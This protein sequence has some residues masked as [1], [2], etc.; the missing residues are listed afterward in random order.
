MNFW[1]KKYSLIILLLIY[2]LSYFLQS[3]FFVD[4]WG[5]FAENPT[6]KTNLIAVFVDKNIYQESKS[7][8]EWYSKDYIQQK[9]SNSKAL[10]LPINV[11]NFGAIDLVRMLE[12]LYFDWVK[13][14]S[15]SLLGAVFIWDIPLPVVENNWFLYPSIFPYVDFK[16]QQF[17]YDSDSKFF[18]SNNNPRGQAEIWHWIVNFWTDHK[19]YSDYFDKLKTYTSDP[20]SFVSRSLRYDDFVAVKE[21]FNI[22]NLPFYVNNFLFLEDVGYHRYTNLMLDYFIATQN[23]SAYD[24]VDS[25]SKDNPDLAN[26]VSGEL[27]NQWRSTVP[28]VMLWS[29]IKELLVKYQSLYADTFLAKIRTNTE[30][31]GRWLKE[32]SSWFIVNAVDSHIHKT[33][34]LDSLVAGDIETGLS[35]LI[36]SFNQLMEEELD[37]KIEKEKRYMTYP[38]VTDYKHMKYKNDWNWLRKYCET[39]VEDHYK[40]YYFGIY[41]WEITSASQFSNY[42]WTFRNLDSFSGVIL[43]NEIFNSNNL[44]SLWAS[45]NLFAT[46]VDANRWYNLFSVAGDYASYEDNKIKTHRRY[47]CTKY[48]IDVKIGKKRY[49]YICRRSAPQYVWE[50]EESLYDFA[51]RWWGWASALNLDEEKM[52]EWI[53]ELKDYNY[54]SSML[55]I[56]DIWGSQAISDPEVLSESFL[57]HSEY[58]SLIKVWDRYGMLE[59]PKYIWFVWDLDNYPDSVYWPI[60]KWYRQ[61]IGTQKIFY[62]YDDLDFFTQWIKRKNW[63]SSPRTN[64]II[65]NKTKE[66]N[67]SVA[68]IW[69]KCWSKRETYIYE[70]KTIDTRIKN[71]LPTPDSINGTYRDDFAEDWLFGKHYAYLSNDLAYISGLL[72]DVFGD[73]NNKLTDLSNKTDSLNGRIELF[74]NSKSTDTATLLNLVGAILPSQEE[75]VYSGVLFDA[76]EQ[77]EDIPS[78]ISEI[79]LW[80]SISYFN[81]IAEI[82]SLY[83]QKT[84]FLSWWS[85]S[86]WETSIDLQKNYKK[87]DIWYST[88]KNHYNNIYKKYNFVSKIEKKRSDL[89]LKCDKDHK[90]LCSKIDALI[91]T[92][93]WYQNTLFNLS[94]YE[95]ILSGESV[96]VKPISI[97]WEALNPDLEEWELSFLDELNY[98]R[99]ELWKIEIVKEYPE[100]TH[101]PWLNQATKDRA[102][103][104]PKNITFQWVWG[105][106]V[107]LVYPN[108]YDIEVY[109]KEGTNLILKSPQEIEASIY[110]YLR[111]KVKEYNTLLSG[112]D[113]KKLKYYTDNASAFDFLFKADELASAKDRKFKPLLEGFFIDLLWEEQISELAVLLYYQTLPVYS[114]K[115][116]EFVE[117]DLNEIRSTFDI[118][119]KIWFIMSGY[120]REWNAD[121]KLSIP[122]YNST[123]YEMA[124]INSDRSDYLSVSD[125]PTFLKEIE[126]SKKSIEQRPSSV[127]SV[128]E[129]AFV[130][131]MGQKCGLDSSYS[132]YLF[133]KDPVS[134]EMTFPWFDSLKCWWTELL[135]YDDFLDFS[136]E[137]WSWSSF[138]SW[139]Q[140]TFEDW[141]ELMK[142]RYNPIKTHFG[143]GKDDEPWAVFEWDLAEYWGNVIAWKDEEEI[144]IKVKSI[145]IKTPARKILAWTQIPIGVSAL[146][147]SGNIIK[148]TIDSYQLSV[149]PWFGEFL[150]PGSSGWVW[151]EFSD[152]V[153]MFLYQA[154]DVS[155]P[156]NVVLTLSGWWLSTQE[157]I[158][159][160]PGN[161]KISFAWH[162]IYDNKKLNSPIN[163]NL[164]GL[165]ST[166]SSLPR[167]LVSLRGSD[168]SD[169]QTSFSVYSKNWLIAPGVISDW[170]FHPLR[171]YFLEKQEQ[172]I[173]LM[174]NYQVWSDELYIQIPWL[175]PI[176]IPVNVNPWNPYRV[177]LITDVDVYEVWE[178]FSGSFL[179][180]DKRW[181]FI[182]EKIKLK[183]WSLGALDLSINTVEVKQSYEFSTTTSEP[184]WMS[185]LYWILDGVSLV[186]QSPAYKKI[187]VQESF[188]PQEDLNVMYLNLFGSDWWNIWSFD[189]SIAE[190]IPN[191]VSNSNK[192]LAVTTLSSTP[193]RL[194]K[195]LWV[196][197]YDGQVYNFSTNSVNLKI[198]SWYLLSEFTN[199]W[200]VPIALSKNISLFS[201]ENPLKSLE[202]YKAKSPA[203][204]ISMED[205]ED[206]LELTDKTLSYSWELLLDL[207]NWFWNETLEIRLADYMQKWYSV[208]ELFYNSQQIWELYFVKWEEEIK[209]D[210]V[211]LYNMLAYDKKTSFAEWTTNW[212]K[213]VWLIDLFWVFTKEGF[214]SIEDSNETDLWIGFTADFKNITLFGDGKMVWEATI[215]FGSQFL[216]N[217]GDPLLSRIS[218][219]LE[220]PN[221]PLDLWIGKEVYTNP[222]KSILKVLDLDFNNDWLMDLL[223]VFTDWTIKLL[224]SYWGTNSYENMD[225]LLRLADSIKDVFVGD[226][227][228]NNYPDI[229]VWTTSD[230]LRVYTNDKWVL[231][232]DGKMI[233]LNT[234]VDRGEIQENPEFI[235][236]LQQVY[237]EDM[238]NDWNIDIVVND[239]IWNIKIFYWWSKW[240]KW[241][242]VST[243]EYACDDDRYNRQ[244]DQTKLVKSF[245]IT[246]NSD[247]YVQDDSL[248]HLKGWKIGDDSSNDLPDDLPDLSFLDNL[249]SASNIDLAALLQN[250]VTDVSDQWVY[251]ML[252]NRFSVAPISYVPSYESGLLLAEVWYKTLLQLSGDQSISIYKQY[253]DLNGGVL[254]DWDT[255]RVTT[256]ILGLNE[257]VKATYID[258]LKWPWEVEIGDEKEILSF[259]KESGNFENIDIVWQDKDDIMFVMDNIDLNNRQTLK[260]SYDLIYRWEPLVKMSIKDVKLEDKKKTRDDYKDIIVNPLDPCEKYRWIFFNTSSQK[261]RSY[262][263]VWDDLSQ[264]MDNYIND[265]EWEEAFSV[266]DLFDSDGEKPKLNK[267]GECDKECAKNMQSIIG[268]A[269]DSLSDQFSTIFESWQVP[270]LSDVFS[271]WWILVVNEFMAWVVDSVDK[272]TDSLCEW[273][274]LG[275]DSCQPPFPLNQI[276]FNQA[277]LAPG[278]YHLF[279]CVP[280]FP[281]PLAPL[282]EI[283]N[284]NLWGGF[285]ALFFPATIRIPAV[286][287][288]VPIP[289]VGSSLIPIMQK[290]PWDGFWLPPF[291]PGWWAFPSMLRVYL[292]PTLTMQMGVAICAGPYMGKLD[293]PVLWDLWWNCV[294]ATFPLYTC[295]EKDE[296][297]IGVVPTEEIDPWMLDLAEQ[298]SCDKISINWM[299]KVLANSVI[300][301]QETKSSPFRLS[302]QWEQSSARSPAA[303]NV[304]L[305]Y[306]S[307]ASSP[308]KN[309]NLN[310]DVSRVRGFNFDPF[311]FFQWPKIDLSV[312]W[313]DEK[314]IINKVVNERLSRQIKYMINNLTKLNISI[315]LPDISQMFEGFDRLWSAEIWAQE[316]EE[317]RQN[318]VAFLTWDKDNKFLKNMKDFASMQNYQ[319]ATS[320]LNNPFD[321]LIG[322]FDEIPLIDLDTKDIVIKIPL[323]TTE[324]LLKYKSYSVTWLDNQ[325]KILKQRIEAIYELSHFCGHM[326]KQEAMEELAYLEEEE[327]RIEKIKFWTIWDWER[328][329]LLD[330]IKIEKEFANLVLDKP[331]DWWYSSDDFQTLFANIS[332]DTSAML[333]GINEYIKSFSYRIKSHSRLKYTK[334]CLENPNLA[335]CEP[336]NDLEDKN[337][338]AELAKVSTRKKEILTCASFAG[339]LDW[340]KEFY[341]DA[342]Q[343]SRHVQQNLDVLDKYTQ[344]PLQLY[345]WM[346]FVDNTISSVLDFVTVLST[347]IIA[348]L[349]VNAKLY[350]KWVDALI[351]IL[352]SIKTYQI[353]IDITA[354]WSKNCG[355]CSRDSFSPYACSF[356]NLFPK[357][358]ILKIPPFKIP[359]INI[360]FSHIDLWINMVLPRFVFVPIDLALPSLPDLPRP[361]N[362]NL[363][364]WIDF[365]IAFDFLLPKIPILPEPPVL[366]DLPEFIPKLDLNLPNL[367]PPA[368]KIPDLIPEL[369]VVLDTVELISKLFC[370]LKS[371]PLVLESR[372]KYKVEQ[373]TQRTRDVEWIDYLDQ[374]LRWNA[375]EKLQ[376]F[377]LQM[378]GYMQFKTDFS[379]F[380]GALN[381][382]AGVINS[383]SYKVSDAFSENVVG[384]INTWSAWMEDLFDETIDDINIDLD[385]NFPRLDIST[386]LFSYDIEWD[387]YETTYKHLNQQLSIIKS[388]VDNQNILSD[389]DQTIASLNAEYSINPMTANVSKA[390]SE[391]NDILIAKQKEVRDISS[392][393]KSYDKF[394]AQIRNDNIAFV[395]DEKIE[396]KIS[397]PIFSTNK[398]TIDFLSKSDSILDTYAETNLNLANDLINWIKS[399]SSEDWG[400]SDEDFVEATSL[401]DSMQLSLLDVA[402]Q[403]WLDVAD[404]CGSS[405]L[406]ASQSCPT[407]VWWWAGTST[408]VLDISN[409]VRWVFLEDPESGAMVNVI[410]SDEF[411]SKI[412]DR[413]FLVDMNNDDLEDMV[414]W[415]NNSVY[416]KYAKQ[417]SEIPNLIVNKKSYV[418]SPWFFASPYIDSYQELLQKTE[419]KDGYVDFGDISVKLASPFQEVKNFKISGQSFDAIQ[420]SWRNSQSLWEPVDWYL[421][422]LN[423][424]IDTHK[425]KWVNHKFLN[426]EFLNQRY[427]LILPADTNYSGA[428]IDFKEAYYYKWKKMDKPADVIEFLSWW[429]YSELIYNVKSYYPNMLN[430]SLG[431]WDIPRNWQYA[432]IVPLKNR[433][434]DDKPD[435]IPAGPWSNQLVAW[436]QILS[437]TIWPE[438]NV[439]LYRPSIEEVVSEWTRHQWFV[440]TNYDLNI[441]WI[442]NVSVANMRIEQDWDI[443]LGKKA[444][445]PLADIQLTGLY[446][447]GPTNLEYIIWAEDSNGNMQLEKVSLEIEVPT[448]DVI[449]YVQISES[450]GQLIAELSDDIDEWMVVFQR[451]R[452]DQRKEIAGTLSNSYGWYFVGPRQ[453]II[454]GAVFSLWNDVGLYDAFG[455]EIW[456]IT[457]DGEISILPEHQAQYEIVL[458]LSSGFPLIRVLDNVSNT[459][460]FWIQMAST[461]L[462]DIS[463]YQRE[464]FYTKLDLTQDM[465]GAFVGGTCIQA[466][467]KECIMYI[468]PIWQIYLPKQFASSL[469][470][471][472]RFDKTTRSVIY[473]IKDFLWKDLLRVTTKT[474][475]AK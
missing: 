400:L 101:V 201:T 155:S 90:V 264:K 239:A 112:Q 67:Q 125:T 439:S 9:I 192:L 401:L 247:L 341:D 322:I 411:I 450:S 81:Y 370:L 3:W 232:V 219:N 338:E 117:W 134:D 98:F 443:I 254:V 289:V 424:R 281:H 376:G 89:N 203:I 315:V 317:V 236:W 176:K 241:N 87:L 425:D 40:N 387:N 421:L 133:L 457:M 44:K 24:L 298:W 335:W 99:K 227:D 116:S 449:D 288:P 418:Y 299:A 100:P 472:Y 277:F 412:G 373:L 220:L 297:D 38:I 143:F 151:P 320:A 265:L 185:Y 142:E 23:N 77:I 152:F 464:P 438:A 190:Y 128:I 78:K 207:S 385:F 362:F 291:P 440:G 350:S 4:L 378:D 120:I 351:L 384:R 310:R 327:S 312:V 217:F 381:Q 221:L 197:S 406:L 188:L 52:P 422:K 230:Q 266:D 267:D 95:E 462:S 278:D 293:I 19:K 246:V 358:P 313:A 170:E 210:D 53:Y 15:S 26:L 344:F 451:N 231:D 290:W 446:F 228:G 235:K 365:A 175:D 229:L 156:Q 83:D 441:E 428:K 124:Y 415:T 473:V 5:V 17:I 62:S 463:L 249:D 54:K 306:I 137:H 259:K 416:I 27:I 432:Q 129:D 154:P 377:D 287:A 325:R 223:V 11:E 433:W 7:D 356:E 326:T 226:V 141:Y 319:A 248:I 465:F 92:L 343:L 187:L 360:D 394:I 359:N 110:L 8:I 302:S 330:I 66:T 214:K 453:T 345:D 413:F 144:W 471:E 260:F 339:E 397:S 79:N 363:S 430:I 286:V 93:S 182:D 157:T 139:L 57:W 169:L 149:Q 206:S 184:W 454:T 105:D 331:D 242:Y 132:E 244:K 108:I 336:W 316:R 111:N 234:N 251:N 50:E 445:S 37:S 371:G 475:L 469:L 127:V 352:T 96:S 279:G 274:K 292:I 150:S 333:A 33:S 85:S 165:D 342:L 86:L 200:Y 436:R 177:E 314:G 168:G 256:T 334:D 208:W 21:R 398:S 97:I 383:F 458:D 59:Y 178:T 407:C 423:H 272:L 323:P 43:K 250:I 379:L 73:A 280:K 388:R 243:L 70:Y 346:D 456:Q 258:S 189:K 65:V 368:P 166:Y 211:V 262:E 431:L 48:L 253:K 273:F 164:T 218:D 300:I 408:S 16:D 130:N 140:D 444:N 119:K 12:N 47:T 347:S 205:S 28:T 20:W 61:I 173:F 122:N 434:T 123:G 147:M 76:A 68:T 233:C 75:E 442:D 271:S 349:N 63:L 159:V 474:N 455:N 380:Y 55:P 91:N 419:S 198:L 104:G 275:G 399:S 390:Y 225:D 36:M 361:P 179:I 46:Q 283:L 375:D 435:Y 10:V 135:D 58:A 269:W 1:Y 382:I 461:S 354:N 282:F 172:A 332:D 366:P 153:S 136:M 109:K 270:N 71:I 114:K 80:N 304:N 409:Y 18:I 268:N 261:H 31:A 212:R 295:N 296:D 121:E 171:S 204:F 216:I 437:D 285:P 22:G 470:G 427:V 393:I 395:N 199:V 276:P 255:V 429:K 284:K 193:S 186:D 138:F 196:V 386:G 106:V 34:L 403:A 88:L 420:M 32:N 364:A 389:I 414:I 84:Q 348:W 145:S 308:I 391:L 245:G 39:T 311:S 237:F 45:N 25:L 163:I 224:K 252:T 402:D 158:V 404:S 115:D 56:Y 82:E 257:W 195:H 324:D 410:K 222:N 42:L 215:P 126:Q 303:S 14:E 355:T 466:L 69:W 13:W 448:I 160:V 72:V 131:Q 467:D 167:I 194:E 369:S 64:E 49:Q 392:S 51:L 396:L 452:N 174:P 191:I 29:S 367:L 209:L 426:D 238:D 240:W 321:A 102:I 74:I 162:N 417:N 60:K 305:G 202:N 107:K 405:T 447:T 329:R 161:L 309:N 6:N 113:A 328:K 301:Q 118:N 307:L 183:I 340:F 263:E 146:D 213:G 94:G 318:A 353:L 181:N 374:T 41:A 294:V 35:P 180:T 148:N 30:A 357:I 468:S 372:L 459:S 2:V 103:D 460:V 337:R